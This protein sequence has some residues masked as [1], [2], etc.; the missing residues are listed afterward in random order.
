MMH[1][2]TDNVHVYGGPDFL[3]YNED[4]PYARHNYFVG[5][6]LGS[7]DDISVTHMR[8]FES[9]WEAEEL[10]DRVKARGTINLEHWWAGNAWDGV[11]AEVEEIKRL[12][13]LGASEGDLVALGLA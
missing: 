10:A 1:I 9:M 4:G 11:K 5:V 12:S 7:D 13:A 3:D 2:D 8:S 6:W